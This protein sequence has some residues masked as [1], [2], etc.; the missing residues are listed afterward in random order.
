MRKHPSDRWRRFLVSTTRAMSNFSRRHII[1]GVLSRT[2][3][4]SLFQMYIQPIEWVASAQILAHLSDRW[5]AAQGG[6]ATGR[7]RSIIVIAMLSAAA[8]LLT[9]LIDNVYLILALITVSLTG[10]ATGISLNIALTSDLLQH[11]QDSA[12]AM[13]IQVSGGNIFGIVADRYR[14]HHRMDGR[15]RHGLCRWRLAPSPWSRANIHPHSEF[16]RGRKR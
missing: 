8:V 9:P 3:D 13:A 15:V 7:R 2:T 14:I 1:D 11:P 6:G 4:R 12:K 5:L 10:L 16:Y